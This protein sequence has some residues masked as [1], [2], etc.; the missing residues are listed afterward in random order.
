MAQTNESKIDTIIGAASEVDGDI[1]VL[2][3]VLVAGKVHGD[4]ISD[5]FVRVTESAVISG[6]MKAKSAI[7]NGKV[8][9]NVLCETR[10]QLGKTSEL[11]GDLKAAR[12]IIE[13]GAVFRGKCEMPTSEEP[14]RVQKASDEQEELEEA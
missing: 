12:L 13:E 4:V 14:V 5:D 10:V 7:I 1:R 6:N 9:G 8:E 11:L 3:S 2:S